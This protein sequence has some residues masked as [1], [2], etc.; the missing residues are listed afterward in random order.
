MK[1]LMSILLLITLQSTAD[2]GCLATSWG[3][4]KKYDNKELHSVQCSCNCFEHG[5]LDKQGRCE[6]CNHAH[7]APG[8]IFIRNTADTTRNTH[9]ASHATPG[10]SVEYDV[11]VVNSAVT[12]YVRSKG[13]RAAKAALFKPMTLTTNKAE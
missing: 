7:A 11:Q 5:L 3:L 8:W 4:T 10:N 2:N 1:K 13:M 9:T 12:T 6:K